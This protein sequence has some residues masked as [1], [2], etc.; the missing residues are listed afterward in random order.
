MKCEPP[1]LVKQY[2]I[3]ALPVLSFLYSDKNSHFSQ[4]ESS[5]YDVDIRIIL[6]R[7]TDPKRM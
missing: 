6:V 1:S 3:Q 2:D 4:Q 7:R 5:H